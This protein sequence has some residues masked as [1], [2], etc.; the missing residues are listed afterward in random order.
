MFEGSSQA[1][2]YDGLSPF[3]FLGGYAVFVI[4]AA[5]LGLM[6]LWRIY[7]LLG[8]HIKLPNVASRCRW[9]W[10]RLP[11]QSPSPNHSCSRLR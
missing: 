1:P 6:V 4:V 10:N 3:L 9:L 5:V 11:W 8:L 7:R 2:W